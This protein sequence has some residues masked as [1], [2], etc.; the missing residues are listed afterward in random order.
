MTNHPHRKAWEGISTVWLAQGPSDGSQKGAE[1]DGEIS[2]ERA[3]LLL[4]TACG[5]GITW[6]LPSDRGVGRR[7]AMSR[8]QPREP[9]P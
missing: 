3:Q 4:E 7:S 6:A 1:H 2:V 5:D 8:V 9:V